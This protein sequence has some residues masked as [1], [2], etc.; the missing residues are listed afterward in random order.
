MRLGRNKSL[1]TILIAATCSACA[2][3]HPCPSLHEWTPFEQ[4]QMADQI[5][6]L[7]ESSMLI[8]ALE[9]YASLRAACR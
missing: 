4:R 8:P 6:D 5:K 1:L 2:P 7:P 3:A 9:D